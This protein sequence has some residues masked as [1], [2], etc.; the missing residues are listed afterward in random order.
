MKARRGYCLA[1]RN[2]RCE[3][4]IV[5]QLTACIVLARGA[6]SYPLERILSTVWCNQSTLNDIR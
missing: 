6:V 2:Y 4:R 5:P 3:T 1:V